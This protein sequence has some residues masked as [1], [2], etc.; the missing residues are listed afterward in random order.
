MPSRSSNAAGVQPSTARHSST[1]AGCSARC[2]CSGAFRWRAQAATT[3][4][5]AGS[6]ARTL[7]M[8]API[9]T[10]FPEV[11]TARFGSS[12]QRFLENVA[13]HVGKAGEREALQLHRVGRRLHVLC[14]REDA[15][16]LD[17]DQ[18]VGGDV[19]EPCLLR[20]PDA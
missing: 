1:S 16:V 12:A 18:H 19:A 10:P 3:R 15:A 2:M 14:H 5:D 9:W 17:L 11:A 8:A 4:I 6:T 13:V 20:V 7:W